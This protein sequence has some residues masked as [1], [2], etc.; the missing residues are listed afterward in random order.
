MRALTTLA[1]K[2]EAMQSFK[3]KRAA[4]IQIYA[5]RSQ[6]IISWVDWHMM[7]RSNHKDDLIKVREDR[8]TALVPSSFAYRLAQYH[9]AKTVCS[10]ITQRLSGL[11]WAQEFQLMHN[12]EKTSFQTY[13]HVKALKPLTD[14]GK[15]S[16]YGVRL[17]H[18][19]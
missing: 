4:I 19:V 8:I 9:H 14:K 13:K 18:L 2:P 10:S 7:S 6:G 5:Q 12:D 1:N 3:D 16:W 15:T 11:G 17:W